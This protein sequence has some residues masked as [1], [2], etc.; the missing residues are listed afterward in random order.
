M[1]VRRKSS[2]VMRRFS[3]VGVVQ[4]LMKNRKTDELNDLTKFELWGLKVN[5]VCQVFR[6]RA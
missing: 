3:T 6:V 4:N 2:N 5:Q 1:S